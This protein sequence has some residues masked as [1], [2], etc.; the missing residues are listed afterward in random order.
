MKFNH[1]PLSRRRIALVAAA[2]ALAGPASITIAPATAHAGGVLTPGGLL[3]STSQWVPA[4]APSITA[5]STELP[6]NCGG[7]TYP[8][9]T[10]A[11]ANANGSYPQ[12]FDNDAVDGSFGVSM[13][14]TLEEVNPT[15]GT[16]IGSIAVPDN[17]ANGDYLS[18]SFSSKSELALNQSTDGQY[19]TFMGYVAPP[20]SVDVSNADTPGAID[21]TNIDSENPTYRAVGQLD[22]NGDFTFTETSSYSGNNGR[23]AIED[24]A[25]GT[26]FMAGNGGNGSKPEPEGVVVGTGSQLIAPS[27]LSEATQTANYG[28]AGSTLTP[29]G[30]F[31][32]YS[33]LGLTKDKTN[34]KDNNYRGLAVYNNVVYL[35]KGSGSN[36]VDTVYYVDTAG[37]TC[38]S[39]SGVPSSRATLPSLSS[40]T[41]PSYYAGSTTNS[42]NESSTNPGL[43]PTNMCVLKGF[44]TSLAS[45]ATDSSDYPFGIWFANPTT[46]Y[47]AD[48]GAG[49]NTYNSSS[50]AYTAAAASTTAGLQKWSFNGTQWVLDYTLQDGLSLGQP[51]AVASNP[52]DLSDP[53]GGVY[54]TGDNTVAECPTPTSSTDVDCPWTPATDGLRNLTGQVNSNG[55]VTIW[56]STSTVSGAGDQG[57]DPNEL[58]SITDT[59]ADSTATQASGESF[60]TVI[61]AQYGQVVRGVSFTPG[62]SPTPETPEVPWA[63]LLPITGVAVLGGAVYLRRRRRNSPSLA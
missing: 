14:I 8:D 44:P 33:E 48:E 45:G 32:A 23:A 52:A 46:L 18:T 10:C 12:V 9:A 40:W 27:T 31:N 49:D 59:V 61:P 1:L 24:P 20:G 53:N 36:G 16:E 29:Y 2:A 6:P 56:A 38:P 43:T 22:G 26:I 62:T 15:T 4:D 63:P 55:T 50:N 42:F 37:G 5:G 57:A 28:S 58:V 21:P 19:V 30:N 51:Y 60:S 41:A 11:T 7:T 13:P 47:V 25:T 17:P 3:V 35:T 34:A 54:P 39:G